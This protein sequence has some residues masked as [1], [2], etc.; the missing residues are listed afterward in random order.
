MA[1]H[2]LRHLALALAFLT[3]LP[4]PL[5]ADRPL[6][7]RRATAWFALAGGLIGLLAGLAG[8]A[9]SAIGLPPWTAAVLVVGAQVL[10]TGALH[11]DGLADVADA[12]GAGPDRARALAIMKDSRIGA[13]GAIALCL[14]L[15]L[16]V[17]LLASLLP[18]GAV[19]ALVAAEALSRAVLPV[20]MRRQRSAKTDGLAAG[21][22]R[23]GAGA[24]AICVISGVA[25]AL[26][27]LPMREALA[28]LPAAGVASLL[29]AAYLGKRFDGY[30]G[31]TLG[32]VQQ[33]VA[34]AVLLA[35]APASVEG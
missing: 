9:A 6:E 26:L 22:G 18:G 27:V 32:A 4:V 10:L 13:Y 34:I 12:M 35:L 8:L 29:A 17:S 21:A 16:R 1:A 5:P 23:P 7:L 14:S 31:D 11:E 25:L 20:V 30:T 19:G 24:V 28:A 15:L 3:R 33:L 2:E